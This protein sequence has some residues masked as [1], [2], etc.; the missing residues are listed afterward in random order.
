LPIGVDSSSTCAAFWFVCRGTLAF[1]FRFQ[2]DRGLPQEYVSFIDIFW[3]VAG[4]GNLAKPGQYGLLEKLR[5]AS[6]N[7]NMTRAFP[8][9]VSG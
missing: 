1:P 3:V 7:S 8:A 2:V 6:Q 4:F 9:C 5:P